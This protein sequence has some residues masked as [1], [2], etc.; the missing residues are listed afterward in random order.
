[1][2]DNKFKLI[3]KHKPSGDQPNAIRELVRGLKEG[4]RHQ[5]LLGVTGSGKTFTVANVIKE[6]QKPTLVIAH[7]K[8]LAAQLCNE[9]RELFPK[10]AVHYFVSYYDYYQPEAYMPITDTYIGKEAMI[11]DEIDKLR[12]AA[13]TALL[14]RNDVIIVASVSCIYGLGAP[15][16]YSENIIH[17]KVGDVIDRKSLTRRLISMQ[18]GRTNSD[19]K[20]STFRLTGDSWE[21]MPPFEE[22]IYSFRLENNKIAEIFVIDPVKG[23]EY[24]KTPTV[25][26]VIVSPARHFLTTV[27]DEKNAAL[28]NI[29]E[30]LK[31]R[32]KYFEST[33]KY[34]EAERLER[35][36]LN[37]LAMIRE[38]GYCHGIENYSRHLS[39]RASGEA[40]ATLLDYFPKDFLMVI[41]ESHVTVP[42]LNGM[43]QGDASRKKTLV[44]YGFRLPS[45]VDNRPLKFREFEK[46]LWQVIYTSAT[47]G[48]YE[49]KKNEQVVEQIIRP[50]GLVD[51]KIVI[52]PATGQI[53]DLIPRIKERIGE[54]ERV[55]VTTLTKKMAEDLSEYLEEA[56]MKV[57]YLHS[58]IK[59]LE[60]IKILTNLRRGNIDVLVG[61]NLLREGLDLPEVSLIAILD[62]DKEGFLRSETSLIQVIGR[63]ARN[64]RGEVLIYADRI[65][66]SIERAVR[67]TDRR[68]KIQEEYNKTH[69]ITPRTI[70]RPITSILPDDILD[71]ELKPLATKS[72]KALELILKEKEREMKEAAKKLDFELAAILRDEIKELIKKVKKHAR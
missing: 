4:M 51:P 68:R 11:N 70:I 24:D 63:A 53:E 22:T 20:R 43:Y 36:T 2:L 54:K 60:R 66:G 44:E 69:N 18:F 28:E 12:H 8:T 33:A 61:V 67:E 34:L 41:D 42:Q 35:R 58:D 72:I 23:F 50:T 57:T 32:L 7:N 16:T 30:E 65:T 5:T 47:P 17:F 6:I 39:G 48:P 15:E 46:R 45:A 21:I 59:T 29:K 9:F 10:N 55:L 19:L 52:R 71:L 62:A 64:V 14:T 31:K 40:P 1:M 38:V 3:S 37:D 26:E 56:G 49:G 25:N 13:T 27:G